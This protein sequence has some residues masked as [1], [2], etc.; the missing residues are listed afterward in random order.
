[1]AGALAHAVTIPGD[2]A[3]LRTTGAGGARNDHLPKLPPLLGPSTSLCMSLLCLFA[4]CLFPRT[5]L[6]HVEAVLLD[7]GVGVLRH[8]RLLLAF[9]LMLSLVD[10][11]CLPVAFW[12]YSSSTRS[13]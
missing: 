13:E 9:C 10:R 5:P 7:V 11:L 4:F 3:H 2:G 1:L 12:I 8:H 6:P